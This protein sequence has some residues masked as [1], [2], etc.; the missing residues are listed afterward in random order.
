MMIHRHMVA[1]R[2]NLAKQPVV[3]PEPVKEETPVVT[4]TFEQ[5]EKEPKAEVEWTVD[6]ILKMPFMKLRSVA[7]K[8]GVEV[9]DKEAK[10]IRS[11]LIEKLG[12]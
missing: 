5:E 6:E 2:N 10:D 11:E 8:N 1:R 7:K 12:L 3:V 9:E 4:E